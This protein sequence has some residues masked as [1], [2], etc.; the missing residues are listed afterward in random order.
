MTKEIKKE[1]LR[2][3]VGIALAGVILCLVL[4]V[5][6]Q[7]YLSVFLGTLTGCLTAWIYFVILGFAVEHPEQKARFFI[8]YI[9]RFGLIALFA[10][11]VL[12]YRQVDPFAALIPLV[13][14][15]LVIMLWAGRGKV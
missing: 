5:L 13:F 11:W 10:Y 8:L 7:R 14:P 1:V 9:L 15:R 3:G 6:R 4:F 12:V 2:M